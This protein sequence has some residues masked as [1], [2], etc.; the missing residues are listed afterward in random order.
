MKLKALIIAVF[1]YA[2]SIFSY[3]YTA[4]SISTGDQTFVLNP[5]FFADGAN[6]YGSELFLAYGINSKIDIWS[7][8]S[9]FQTEGITFTDFSSM[10]RYD[11]GKSNILAVRVS[12]WY[13]SP[14]YH[15]TI[16]NEVFAFQ[17][18]VAAQFAYLKLDRSGEVKG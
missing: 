1:L 6:G 16:E 12:P 14:Q 4:F 10:V 15:L 13:V 17:A 18:N 5:Y 3:S 2:S 9:F 11:L 8:V 7:D